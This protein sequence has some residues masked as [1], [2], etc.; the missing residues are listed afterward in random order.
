MVVKHILYVLEN[1]VWGQE[2]KIWFEGRLR[3]VAKVEP[4][5]DLNGVLGGSEDNRNIFHQQL[6]TEYKHF[7]CFICSRT[8]PFNPSSAPLT[9]RPKYKT[10]TG[11]VND[12]GYKQPLQKAKIVHL[13]WVVAMI[14]FFNVVEC[15]VEI[16]IN[17][18]CSCIHIKRFSSPH[19]P[20]LCCCSLGV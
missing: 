8:S 11:W 5:R 1:R 12:K 7:G 20:P 4:C 17:L 16:R 13:T 14:S 2:T 9:S 18:C 19:L 15:R 3:T 10:L 6:I